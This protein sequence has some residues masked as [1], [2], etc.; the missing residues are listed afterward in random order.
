MVIQLKIQIQG[1]T[2]PS[3]WR[4]LLIP[5]T[6]TFRQLH[7]AIQL[8]FGWG[9]CHL[10]Q[11]EKQAYSH[12]WTIRE[13][14]EDDNFS[15]PLP[16]VKTHVDTF[17]VK[18][19]L[20]NFVYVYDFGDSW[21]HQITV[22]DITRD[23]IKAPICLAGKGDTP[24]ED[25]GGIFGYEELKELLSKNPK[26]LTKDEQERVDWAM[27]MKEEMGYNGFDLVQVN[28]DLSTFKEY[29]KQ[30]NRAWGYNK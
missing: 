28:E 6:F 8:A 3:V 9:C 18:N 17:I 14:A 2:K 22:E 19:G 13:P 10:Y 26:D 21:V 5:A 30:M 25:C 16:A 11:F 4:R 1:I 24:P 20:K 27:E 29:E 7:Y 12:D 15:Q 23:N